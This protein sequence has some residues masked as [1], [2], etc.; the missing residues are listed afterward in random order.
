M[1]AKCRGLSNLI[2][3]LE[4][5]KYYCTK[6]ASTCTK[7]CGLVVLS[8]FFSTGGGAPLVPGGR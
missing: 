5:M 6:V 1:R 3:A 4:T 8:S 2:I 7:L